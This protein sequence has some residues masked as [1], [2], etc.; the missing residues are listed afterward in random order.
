MC[1][2]Q[3]DSYPHSATPLIEYA[4]TT[5][6]KDLY[7]KRKAYA[8]ASIREYWV[9][10][11]KHRQLSVFRDPVNGDYASAETLTMGEIGPKAFSDVVISVQRL[12]EG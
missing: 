3:L 12:L 11:L 8:A 10:D 1:L 2:F 9:V 5:L 4:N 7:T 6:S